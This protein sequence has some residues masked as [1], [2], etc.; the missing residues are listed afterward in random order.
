MAP[1]SDFLKSRTS[2]YEERKLASEGIDRFLG[3]RIEACEDAIRAR[4]T[5]HE[6]WSRLSPQIFQTPYEELA[7]VVERVDP[8]HVASSWA[9]LGAGYG[10]LGLVLATLRPK[11]Q[12]VG[13]E[14]E[15]ERVDE[16]NRIFKRLHLERARLLE[17]DLTRAPLPDAAVYFI[18]DFGTREAVDLVLERLRDRA[19]S[20]RV[21]VV[22]R[23]RRIRDAIERENPWLSAVLPPEHSQHYSIYRSA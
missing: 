12:F 8:E 1:L 14:L 15:P 11:S 10:R 16:A 7:E 20:E 2:T 17:G 22:G 3:F 9:D 23:G 5:E 6:N 21:I 19:R 4:P 13:I 18:Y